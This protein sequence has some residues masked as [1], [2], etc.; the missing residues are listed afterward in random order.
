M[1]FNFKSQPDQMIEKPT[2]N[3]ADHSLY[4]CTEPDCSG[5]MEVTDISD[6]FNTGYTDDL[7]A[8]HFFEINYDTNELTIQGE[9][10]EE[11]LEDICSS[12]FATGGVP[13]ADDVYRRIEILTD[14]WS[15]DW[16]EEEFFDE[17][18]EPLN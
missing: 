5:E 13:S 6:F 1:K 4:N 11:E 9:L 17:D 14:E 2:E 12:G 10:S 16:I 18:G 8:G 15:I 7:V 3:C